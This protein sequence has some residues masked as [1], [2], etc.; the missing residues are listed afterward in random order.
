MRMRLLKAKEAVQLGE[1]QLAALGEDQEVRLHF[2]QSYVLQGLPEVGLAGHIF[3]FN[4][5]FEAASEVLERLGLHLERVH[6][7][8]WKSRR[9]AGH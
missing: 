9:R 1:D 7:R 5:C 4:E 8:G 3:A 6:P 2:A